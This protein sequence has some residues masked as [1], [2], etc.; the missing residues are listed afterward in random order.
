VPYGLQD[1]FE[2]EM[3]GVNYR[4]KTAEAAFKGDP[5][6]A[7]RA[8]AECAKEERDRVLAAYKEA[9]PDVFE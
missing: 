5:S 1:H 4:V 6:E 2:D 3:E 7:N 9:C 8:R